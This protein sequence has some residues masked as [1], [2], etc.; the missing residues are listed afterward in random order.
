[1]NENLNMFGLVKYQSEHYF[2]IDIGKGRG[3]RVRIYECFV[4]FDERLLGLQGI[5]EGV[6]KKELKADISKSQWN[7]IASTLKFEFNQ[8]L[9]QQGNNTSNWT[10]GENFTEKLIGKE[11]LLLIWS[12]E[13][14]EDSD[15]INRAILN[16]RG[17]SREE[18]WWL[19]TIINAATGTISVDNLT[20]TQIGWRSAIKIAFISNPIKKDLKKESVE[21]E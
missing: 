8:I 6:L 17:F 10:I 1:M 15:D 9:K 16:W 7:K 2:L 12:I 14:T 20:N 11:L 19:F 21:N 5:D 3:S 13:D 18:R 4:E